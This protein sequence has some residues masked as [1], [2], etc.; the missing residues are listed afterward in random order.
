VPSVFFYISGHGFGH[1]SR[2]IE[3]VNALLG[4][5]GQSHEVV[6]RTSAA[7]W[8]FD[9]TVR[10]AFT[11][12][13]GPCDTGVVQIDSLRLDARETIARAEAFYRHLPGRVEREAALLRARDARLVISDA[14]PLACAA[15][16]AARVPAV[17]L[18]NFTWDWIYEG[19]ADELK[20]APDLIPTIREAYRGASEAWRL[21][22][23]GGF[24][25]FDRL[26]DVPFIA[27]HAAYDRAT[28]RQRF[29][30]PAARRLALSSFGGYGVSDF[31]LHR[32]DCLDEW[33]VI[34]TGRAEP[35]ALPQ[36]VCFLDERR[37]YQAGFRYE[38]IVAAVDVV[39]TKPG[40]GIVAEC[41]ANNTAMLYTSR[42][43][44]VEYDVMVA[45][46]PRFLR[47]E[48]VAQEDMLAGRWRA[49]LERLMRQPGPPEHPSTNGAEVVAGMIW[50]RLA[51]STDSP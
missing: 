36:G 38:D 14:P 29:T 21:P 18:S 19:Y 48:F 35:P 11:Y 39:V 26:V 17:V 46:M 34:V 49:P 12:L 10:G 47:C 40:F 27:R 44:F 1:A 16:R 33:A 8:L 9:R 5:A 22:V 6:I 7:P 51:A 20:S 42:G 43:H 41:L 32:L 50:D 28:V 45:E 23:H 25:T 4:G 37:I 30:L 15:A 31:D 3:V 13:D 2:E 24:E